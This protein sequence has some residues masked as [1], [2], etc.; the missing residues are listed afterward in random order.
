MMF[1][2]VAGDTEQKRR[3]KGQWGWCWPILVR[4]N[5]R[6]VRGPGHL[7]MVPTG[8]GMGGP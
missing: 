7:L 6:N 2:V 3:I 5:A 1:W 8:V 4:L